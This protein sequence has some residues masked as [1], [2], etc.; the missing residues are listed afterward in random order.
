M[1]VIGIMLWV[2]NLFVMYL[3]VRNAIDNSRNTELL[4]QNQ[5]VLRDIRRLLEEHNQSVIQRKL[6][7]EDKGDSSEQSHSKE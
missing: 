6:S 2:F 3:V 7:T 1:E 4:R 5:Q